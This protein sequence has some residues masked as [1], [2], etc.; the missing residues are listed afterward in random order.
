MTVVEWGAGLVEQLAEAR[1]EIEI[2]RQPGSEVR[3][4]RLRPTG[5]DWDDRLAGLSGLAA[6]AAD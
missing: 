3:T 5:G 2:D 4:V 1:L 6:V